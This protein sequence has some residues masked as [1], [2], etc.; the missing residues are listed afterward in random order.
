M[1]EVLSVIGVVE[2]TVGGGEGG[3]SDLPTSPAN[4]PTA[5]K[6]IKCNLISRISYAF[7][8]SYLN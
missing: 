8:I 2:E 5:T 3:L 4:K 1:G 6:K 7:I